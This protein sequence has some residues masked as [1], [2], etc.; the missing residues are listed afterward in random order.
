M[1]HDS[2]PQVYRTKNLRIFLL[3]HFKLDPTIKASV[4]FTFSCDSNGGSW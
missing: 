2:C 1:P 3:F 4:E